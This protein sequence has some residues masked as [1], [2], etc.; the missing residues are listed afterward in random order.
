MNLLS[1]H[2]VVFFCCYVFWGWCDCI[3]S[4]SILTCNK[5]FK[6]SSIMVTAPLSLRFS[7]LKNFSSS[8]KKGH[9]YF[10]LLHQS[11]HL[12]TFWSFFLCSLY[13]FGQSQIIFLHTQYEKLTVQSESP[14]YFL[15]ASLRAKLAPSLYTVFQKICQNCFLSNFHRFW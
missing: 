14:W 1:L 6:T 13:C 10:T 5:P 11:E 15:A 7:M 12:N 8:Q 4:L 9:L 3:V 2:F